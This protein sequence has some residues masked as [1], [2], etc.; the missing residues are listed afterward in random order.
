MKISPKIRHIITWVTLS[1][2]LIVSMAFVIDSRNKALC[3]SIDVH[4]LDSNRNRFI[5]ETDIIV[6]LNASKEK[7]LGYGLI[8]INTEAL[9][10]YVEAF[11]P[12]KKVEIYYSI[13]GVMNFD[14]KQREPIVRVMGQDFKSYYI[15][16]EGTIMPLSQ[17][18]TSYVPVVSGVVKTP[19]VV[20]NASS[21]IPTD[22][23]NVHQKLL[24][25]IYLLSYYIHKH[26]FWKLQVEQIYINSE[27]EFELIPRIG[28]QL[29]IFG[30]I[31]N[32]EYKFGK[33]KSFYLKTLP[34]VGW[35]TYNE[36]NIQYS[37]QIICKKR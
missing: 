20:K 34:Y 30:D 32:Y 11:P 29:I 12:V 33:L 8:S 28:N 21:V 10:K 15:D 13:N 1:L 9:E 16:L 2:Y 4:I 18:Y 25:D 23:A 19:F 27:R 5:D 31:D 3:T 7:F 36:I 17:K 6:L 14:V 26:S 22:S 35:N 37:N 24:Y